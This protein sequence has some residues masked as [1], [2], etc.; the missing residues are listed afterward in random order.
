M[1]SFE[2]QRTYLDNAHSGQRQMLLGEN[3]AHDG[4]NAPQ[5]A[6]PGHKGA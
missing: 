3:L 5:I 2:R 1:G 6:A 4:R